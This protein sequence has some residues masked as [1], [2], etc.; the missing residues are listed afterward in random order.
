MRT[1]MLGRLGVAI[2]LAGI[3]KKG[4][5]NLMVSNEVPTTHDREGYE[6]LDWE[7]PHGVVVDEPRIQHRVVEPPAIVEA[8]RRIN[9]WSSQY[10]EDKLKRDLANNRKPRGC[11]GKGRTY[12]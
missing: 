4:S 8:N 11:R 9:K 6:A 12:T 10:R 2:G 5:S 3:A 7:G 1:G